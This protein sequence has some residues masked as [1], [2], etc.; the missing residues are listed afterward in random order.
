MIAHLP[1]V[2]IRLRRHR[3]ADTPDDTP[4]IAAPWAARL[5]R[6]GLWAL[7]VLGAL[8]GL[9]A[10]VR[11]T[12][13][14]IERTAHQQVAPPVGLSGVAEISVRQWLTGDGRPERLGTATPTLAVDSVAAVALR[15]I[16][17]DYWGVTVAAAVRGPAS[18][19]ATLWYLEVGVTSDSHGLRPVGQPAVVPAPSDPSPV[20]G[21]AAS[22]GSPAPGDPLPATAEAFLRALLTG[23]GDPVRYEAPDAAIAPIEH[24]PFLE[25]T[26]DRTAVLHSDPTSTLLRVAVIATTADH[27]EFTVTYEL[28]LAERAG[29]WEIKALSAAPTLPSANPRPSAPSTTTTPT[30]AKAN[31][32]TSAPSPG[33]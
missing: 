31:T 4:G 21:A 16:T 27:I 7:V 2:S 22:L 23:T 25:L 20:L 10:A 6:I 5:P 30:T 26:V 11:P 8:G 15:P 18:Q 14:V 19:A 17:S 1:V 13:T 12:T 33:A 32:P 9:V 29:R 24:P 3:Q 28:V